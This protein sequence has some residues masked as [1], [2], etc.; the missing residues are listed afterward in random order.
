MKEIKP[1][2]AEWEK[3]LHECVPADADKNQI[4]AVNQILQIMANHDSLKKLPASCLR[5]IRECYNSSAS[6]GENIINLM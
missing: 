2:S 1:L 3:Y 6:F 4:L 5:E